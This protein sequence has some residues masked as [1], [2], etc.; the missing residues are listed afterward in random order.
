MSGILDQGPALWKRLQRRLRPGLAPGLALWVVGAGGP[1]HA[2]GP[3][4]PGVPVRGWTILSSSEPDARAVIAAAPAY[5]INHLE[6]SHL[7][8]HDLREIKDDARCALVNRLID[9]AHGAGIAEVVLWDHALYP[10]DYYPAEFRTGPGG[11]LDLDDPAFWEWLKA[12]YRRMLDRV[13][14][15]D[16]LVLTFIETGARAE[17]QHSRKLTTNQRRLAAVVDAVADVV[18]GERRLNLYAR[19]FSYS[20]AEYASIIG[21]VDLIARPEVR[22]MMKETPHDF[23]LTHPND[24][25]AGSVPRP[26]LIEFDAAGEFHG[27]GIVAVT[28]P[29]Y[30]LGRWRDLSRRPHVI[31]YTARTD[32]YGDTRLVGRPGEINLLALKRGTEDPEVTA[33]QVYDE[34]ITGRY[35]AEALPEVKAA[36][37]RAFEIA[38]CVFYTLGTNV[39]NHSQLNYDP[40]ASSYVLHVSGKWLDPP[41]A[42]VG[43]GVDRD[44]HYWRDVVDHLAPAFVKAPDGRQWREVPW[45]VERGFVHPG[46]GMNEEYLRYVVTEKSHGVGAAEAAARHVENAR[47]A[48][49]PGDHQ[50]LH[51]HFQH[52]LLTARLRRAAA[53]AY[54]GF[55]VWCRGEAHRTRYV[56]D[57]VQRGLAEIREVAGLIRGYPVKPPVGQWDWSKDADQA[58]G[59]FRM[60][61]HEGWPRET[62]GVPNPNAGMTFPFS[63][64]TKE[65]EKIGGA[66]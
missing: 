11:T 60:I 19:T 33:E 17:R 49:A 12:D 20:H 45:V 48:L 62:R 47:T 13:P 29:E 21:A 16:G 52:T 41:V 46:E 66:P 54:F 56:R 34:F 30:V 37:K 64:A 22:L 53:A 25:H 8:V 7:I 61:V 24:R 65:T 63:T 43:H 31:G 5:G 27:Q 2:A 3:L 38:T 23:F 57:T 1:S 58:E 40:S 39:A 14:R 55:R 42:W 35:G 59:Y 10:L 26:T 28:W 36:F 6:L 44:F 32:R 51:H 9:A 15:A 4:P 18:V 50:S